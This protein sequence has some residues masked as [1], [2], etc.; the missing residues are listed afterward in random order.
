M[1]DVLE[2]GGKRDANGARVRVKRR[3]LKQVSADNKRLLGELDRLNVELSK[4]GKAR[5]RYI[6]FLGILAARDAQA[7]GRCVVTLEE[8]RGWA[9]GDGV[10][11]E[12]N[13]EAKRIVLHPHVTPKAVPDS[14]GDIAEEVPDERK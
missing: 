6:R 5:D 1:G 11:F 13:K 12:I 10:D 14:D 4:M 8:I 2:F 9:E 7:N 3:S